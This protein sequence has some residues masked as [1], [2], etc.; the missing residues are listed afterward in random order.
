LL[1]YR[2]YIEMR[3]KEQ[4]SDKSCRYYCENTSLN[5]ATARNNNSYSSN[6]TRCLSFTTSVITSNSTNTGQYFDRQQDN[7]YS[8]RNTWFWWNT[9]VAIRLCSSNGN[10]DDNWNRHSIPRQRHHQHHHQQHRTRWRTI[11]LILLLQ[12][13]GSIQTTEVGFTLVSAFTLSSSRQSIQIISFTQDPTKPWCDGN[14]KRRRLSCSNDLPNLYRTTNTKLYVDIAPSKSQQKTKEHQQQHTDDEPT[15]Q[16][17]I[18]MIQ[19]TEPSPDNDDAAVDVVQWNDLLVSLQPIHCDQEDGECWKRQQMTLP[20]D[21][22]TVAPTRNDMTNLGWTIFGA[23]VTIILLIIQSGPG[24]WR[25][26]LAGAICATASHVIPVPI[27]TVKTRKQVDPTF[28]NV[29]F[30]PA[31]VRIWQQEGIKGLLA[32]LGPTAIG[33]ALEGGI[34]FGV[35]EALKPVMT[36]VLFRIAMWSSWFCIFNTQVVSFACCA[37]LSGVAASIVLC[38]M[39]A[40]RIRMVANPKSQTGWIRTAVKMIQN[41]GMIS[42]FKGMEPMIYKQVPYTITKNVAFDFITRYAYTTIQNTWQTKTIGPTMKLVVPFAAASAASVL[43]CLASQPGDVLLSLV[44]AQKNDVRR[45]RDILHDVLRSEKGWKG[46]FVGTKARLLH[47]GIVVTLQLLI[48]DLVK[49][50]CGIAATGIAG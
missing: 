8:H 33:Y 20:V 46:F 37:A 35:Y 32:G 17:Q 45:T 3:R 5:T 43:S 24:A 6:S 42:L 22:N 27:D 9:I 38:P 29:P 1:P 11:L 4:I 31:F 19:K 41:E 10:I 7:K 44:N 13:L 28:A 40:L 23:T 21:H 2:I 50:I 30:V 34:K 49:R 39:E 18:S 16:Q 12:Y 15:Q 14:F 26:Y 25:Y 36:Q 47:V 48:Y